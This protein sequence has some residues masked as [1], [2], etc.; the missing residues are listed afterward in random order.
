M[1]LGADGSGRAS[2]GA[3]SKQGREMEPCGK[4][5]EMEPRN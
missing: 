2:Q 1:A 4:E 3:A 5:R